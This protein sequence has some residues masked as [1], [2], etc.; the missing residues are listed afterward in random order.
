MSSLSKDDQGGVGMWEGRAAVQEARVE[1]KRAMGKRALLAGRVSPLPPKSTAVGKDF[2]LAHH[3]LKR[4]RRAFNNL[5]IAA[6][7][8][9][10]EALLI[11]SIN[12]FAAA[13]KDGAHDGYR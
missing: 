7:D 8:N 1:R 3:L 11:I 5:C 2:H 12:K 4:R 13:I 9:Q 10:L 6:I